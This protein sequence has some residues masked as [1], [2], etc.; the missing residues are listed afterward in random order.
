VDIFQ[1]QGPWQCLLS[2]SAHGFGG[3]HAEHRAHALA[4]GFQAVAGSLRQSQRLATL[5]RLGEDHLQKGK[6]SLEIGLD[7]LLGVVH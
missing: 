2:G 5:E 6:Q 1:G 4:P 3:Q 7:S